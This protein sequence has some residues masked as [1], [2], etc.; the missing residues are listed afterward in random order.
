MGVSKNNGIPKSSILV[1][2]SNINHPFWG[3]SIFWNT[4]ILYNYTPLPSKDQQL[5]DNEI[6]N[7]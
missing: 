7:N 4:L 1:G 5:I 6:S 3:T 2:F